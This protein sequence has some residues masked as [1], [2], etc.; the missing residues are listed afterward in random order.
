[1]IR[2]A[3]LQHRQAHEPMPLTERQRQVVELYQ[4]YASVA[5]EPP[6]TGWLARRLNI[7]RQHAHRHLMAIRHKGYLA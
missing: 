6:S 3:D 1:M 7:S 2:S 5:E 4:R